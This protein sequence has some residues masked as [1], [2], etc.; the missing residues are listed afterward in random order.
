MAQLIYFYGRG[1]R[2]VHPIDGLRCAALP[3][4]P[5]KIERT[6]QQPEIVS[7]HARPDHCVV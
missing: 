5:R 2:D 1:R 3:Q 4:Q 7:E 6:A